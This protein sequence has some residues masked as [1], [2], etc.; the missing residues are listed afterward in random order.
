MYCHPDNICV[1]LMAP[2]GIAA[3]NLHA[4]SIHNTFRSG[5]DVHIPY[6]VL[7]EEKVNSLYAKYCDLW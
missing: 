2:T 5:K 6:T 7:G 3:Y 1:L 4:T